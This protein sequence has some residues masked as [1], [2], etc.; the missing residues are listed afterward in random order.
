M[1]VNG[2]DTDDLTQRQYYYYVKLRKKSPVSAL[3]FLKQCV[4]NNISLG[5]YENY[6]GDCDGLKRISL[7]IL[8][9]CSINLQKL[10]V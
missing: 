7:D 4:R 5:M 3:V 9:K 8:E 10:Y 2:Y 6:Y 1:Y